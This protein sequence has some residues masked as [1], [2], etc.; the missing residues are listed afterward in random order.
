MRDKLRGEE[1]ERRLEKS[2]EILY[3]RTKNSIQE[4]KAIG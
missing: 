4:A 1:G 2:A 3:F